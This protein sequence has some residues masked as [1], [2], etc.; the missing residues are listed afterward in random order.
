MNEQFVIEFIRQRMHQFGIACYH[1]EPVSFMSDV[2]KPVQ[3]QLYNEWWYLVGFPNYVSIVS[4]S[5]FYHREDSLLNTSYAP[6]FTGNLYISFIDPT[7]D[8]PPIIGG[9]GLS[10]PIVIND[11][12]DLKF[13]RVIIQKA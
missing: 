5:A 10:A 3:M 7:I 8:S 1:F 9:G 2:N 13:I 4:D 12:A 11:G 6:E